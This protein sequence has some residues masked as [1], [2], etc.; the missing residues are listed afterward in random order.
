M[1]SRAFRLNFMFDDAA[2]GM[3]YFSH[4]FLKY[5]KNFSRKYSISI[6]SGLAVTAVNFLQASC[7][8]KKDSACSLIC[9]QYITYT[10]HV[11]KIAV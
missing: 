8:F 3:S 11:C 7:T 4:I 6:F 10:H 1:V 2:A 5:D 9:Y